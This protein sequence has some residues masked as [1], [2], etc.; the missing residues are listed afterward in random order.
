MR[1][2]TGA[3]L[4]GHSVI[5]MGRRNALREAACADPEF[6]AFCDDILLLAVPPKAAL[7]GMF[8]KKGFKAPLSG[9]TAAA[10]AKVFA[11]GVGLILR[12][13]VGPTASK[14]QVEDYW[15]VAPPNILGIK[16]DR[17]PYRWSPENWS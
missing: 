5:N 9:W 4:G 10:A 6:I 17:T 16:A 12:S 13:E 1:R 7:A 15:R 8:T 3:Y 2:S 11:Q 14:K